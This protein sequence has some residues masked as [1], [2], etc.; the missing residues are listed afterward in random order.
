VAEYREGATQSQDVKGN[1]KNTYLKSGRLS[2]VLA[3][4][5]VLCFDPSAHRSED[6]L[7]E[8]LQGSPLSADTWTSVASEHPEF[9]RVRP[10]GECVVSLTARHVIPKDDAGKRNLPPGLA[11]KLMEMAIQIHDRQERRADWWKAYV[12]LLIALIAVTGTFVNGYLQSRD[13]RAE[14]EQ[15][16]KIE[17]QKLEVES[18]RFAAAEVER[19]AREEDRKTVLQELQDANQR[20]SAKD[21]ELVT[22]Q[23]WISATRGW[24]E[25]SITD[26]NKKQAEEAIEKAN[27]IKS[28][29]DD[30]LKRRQELEN[31]L[32]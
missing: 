17:S 32:R 15:R 26:S 23:S 21:Q 10:D 12:P 9:F 27:Q 7:R 5:Q 3:L 13:A 22:A 4:I 1:M 11:E 24:L 6:G 14:R 28:D 8:D 31:R 2:D 29:R 18:K 25:M 30:L 16:A 19:K 20:I